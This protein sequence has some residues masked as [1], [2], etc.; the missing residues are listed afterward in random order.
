VRALLEEPDGTLWV[1][2]Y[3]GLSRFTGNGFETL[4]SKDGLPSDLVRCL[5]RDGEGALWVGTYGGGIARLAGGRISAWDM[6]DG[7]YTDVAYGI[8]E[9]AAGNLWVGSNRG[10]YRVSRH[11]LEARSLRTGRRLR[12]R[13]FGEADGMASAECNGGDPAVARDLDGRLYFPTV[14]GV[15]FVDPAR[16]IT[17]SPPEARIESAL[18]EGRPLAPG[19]PAEIPSGAKRFEFRY[20]ALNLR[21][22]KV[23]EFRYR[24]DG[25]DEQWVAA[26][27]R[28][29]AFYTNIPPGSYTFRVVAGIDGTFGRSEST[30]AFRLARV[31]WQTWWAQ[32]TLALALA[33]LA[34]LGV[35]LRTRAL[36]R[37]RRSLEAAVASRSAELAAAN[38]EL[39]EVA[40][41]DPLTK[42][43]NRRYFDMAIEGELELAVRRAEA[44]G[45]RT[46]R[47][48]VL[49]IVDLDHFKEVNDTWGHHAGDLVLVE[50]ARRLHGALRKTD[51]LV[52]WGGEEFLVL[53]RASDRRKAQTQAERML[54]VIGDV[55]FEVEGKAISRTCS[56]GW[57]PFPWLEDLPK[58]VAFE[59]V[60]GLADR[61][62]YEAKASGR[63]RAIGYLPADGPSAPDDVAPFELPAGHAVRIV[64]VAGHAAPSARPLCLPYRARNGTPVRMATSPGS[65]AARAEP[66]VLS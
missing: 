62:L 29:A 64:R 57:A 5:Y 59:D 53:A 3:G 16:L 18:V 27:P 23:T 31:W 30:F 32:L 49:Y 36:E 1:A 55:P 48:V 61:A 37:D 12:C 38:R 66:R 10:V 26:G 14:R 4:T 20:A 40:V 42:A 39:E 21:S 65:R 33:G 15:A 24:L 13:S 60:V 47:D 17:P 46:N 43:K 7:L 8:T 35:H 50:T 25:F 11:D 45:P 2:T 58:N 52:R 19:A 54:F 56:I 41:T 9:D 28:R 51:F 44:P 22:S 63:N 6:R 34:A